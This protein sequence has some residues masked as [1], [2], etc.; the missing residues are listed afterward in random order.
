MVFF[1]PLKFAFYLHSI[2]RKNEKVDDDTHIFY[3][4]KKKKKKKKKL[5]PD[6]VVTILLFH[7]NA[8]PHDFD[9]FHN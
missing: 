7:I 8:V 9:L 3:F 1:L 4:L 5:L 6:F 2:C